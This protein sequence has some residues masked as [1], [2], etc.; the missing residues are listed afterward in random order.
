MSEPKDNSFFTGALKMSSSED[1]QQQLED[2]K[3]DI[4]EVRGNLEEA[5]I[6]FGK[7][8]GL[9]AEFVA[10]EKILDRKTERKTLTAE[11]KA[12]RNS[13][14]SLFIDVEKNLI[15]LTQSNL[16]AGDALR[17]A[18]YV[19]QHPLMTDESSRLVKTVLILIHMH[20][21][22]SRW[23]QIEPLLEHNP[24]L[25]QAADATRAILEK[26]DIAEWIDTWRKKRRGQSG[27]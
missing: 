6:C 9:F 11:Q 22:E 10:R 24:D 20:I 17:F 15:G 27:D 23:N 21:F 26:H 12:K 25:A 18:A 4:G 19:A 7:W 16:S 14:K 3:K 2:I 1:Y 8:V 5:K 13:Y